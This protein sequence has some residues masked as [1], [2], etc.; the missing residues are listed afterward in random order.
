MTGV[1]FE[2]LKKE[3]ESY[4][5]PYTSNL[6]FLQRDRIRNEIRYSKDEESLSRALAHASEIIGELIFLE[7]IK[8]KFNFKLKEEKEEGQDQSVLQLLDHQPKKILYLDLGYS[9]EKDIWWYGFNLNGKEAIITSDGKILRNIR[10]KIK[11]EDGKDKFVGENEIKEIFDYSSYIGDIAP[12]IDNETI[13]KFYQK[14]GKNDLVSPKE[15]YK[16]IRN[17]FLYYMDF[18][19]KEEIAD[20]MTCWIIATY[21][22]PIF[23]WFPHILVNA[24]SGSGKTKFLTI[25]KQLAF[26]G[27][28]IGASAGVTPAQIFRTLESN[29]GTTIFD[30]FEQ[31]VST[32]S[33][34]LVN[35]IIN[36]SPTK[37]A[38]VIRTEQINR[39]W[40]AWKFPIFCPK[41][42]GNISGINPTSL[43]R[44]IFF[45]W[46]KTQTEKGK[47]KPERENDKK[48]FYL[49][50]QNLY[51]LIL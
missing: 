31:D 24:P 4:I 32:E 44:F 50:Q 7:D 11:Y 8:E 40:R 35:Q 18:S 38:Y 51:I 22:Y 48:S 16:N 42:C 5:L 1:D 6:A 33:K 3:T 47:R 12:I 23:N 14:S 25:I 9:Q 13:K 46:L 27:F 39:K 26:R 21:C 20:V 30:E 49:I 29:R 10:E 41:A 28:D 2:I 43:S 19:G 37:D 45:K 17:K 36:A 15:V 34:L